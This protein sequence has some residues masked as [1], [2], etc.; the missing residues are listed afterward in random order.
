MPFKFYAKIKYKIAACRPS[1]I[2]M[3][4]RATE[5]MVIK[6]TVELIHPKSFHSSL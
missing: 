6:A 4:I 1:V 5:I 2:F 3:S